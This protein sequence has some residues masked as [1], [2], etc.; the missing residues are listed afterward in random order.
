[1]WID[2]S[3]PLHIDEL[4]PETD[5]QKKVVEFLKDWF[6]D[7]SF[8]S[9]QTS[10]S[11][12][13]PKIFE[14]EKSRMLNSAQATCDFLNLKAGDHALLCLPIEY[15]SG[16]MMVVRAI[17][18]KLRLKI[19][20][21][22]T[23][24]L[25]GID[26]DF[27]FSALTPLQVQH[28]L[29]QLSFIKNLIIGGAAVSKSL[30]D[31]IFKH[32]HNNQS[33]R[34]FETYGMSETLSHIALKEIYPTT[35][36][37][38][39][40]FKNVEISLDSRGCLKIFAP[41]VCSEILSTNDLVE[42]KGENKFRFLGRIDH[43]INSG[44]AKIFPESLENFVKNHLNNEVVFLGIPDDVLGQKLIAV[45]ELLASDFRKKEEVEKLFS[46]LHF[47]KSFY[48]PKKILFTHQLPRT[49]NGKIDRLALAEQLKLHP[50]DFF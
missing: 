21:P 20:D 27:N 11:T 13:K 41:K 16:K 10:G 8:V 15:I 34:I 26:S 50:S 5:F 29:H 44:G 47:E 43:V 7:T 35:E 48:R 45:V 28:S 31:E 9:V 3:Q 1:M 40:A 32:L 24:P 46:E 4:Q 18:R 42:I 38:F 14:V 6:S 39:T 25:D 36:E 17:E 49:Q 23:H 2:F 19:V 30:T 12:G 37:F 33:V 22:S